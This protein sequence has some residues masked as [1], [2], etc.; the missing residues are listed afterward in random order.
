MSCW[1][2]DVS[3]QLEKGGDA[4]L[5]A[6]LRLRGWI[7]YLSAD[8]DGCFLVQN[9]LKA[10]PRRLQEEMAVELYGH[11][12]DAINSPHANFVIQVLVEI[13]PVPSTAFIAHELA[14]LATWVARHQYG[15]RILIRLLEHSTSQDS[16][17]A[18]VN[19]LLPHSQALMKHKF[20]HYVVRAVLEH[21]LTEQRRHVAAAM[22][23]HGCDWDEVL[24]NAT[25]RNAS[26]VFEAALAF[27]SRDD[28]QCFCECLLDR[29]ASVLELARSEFGCFVLKAL[30]GCSGCPD[31]HV[32]EAL[33][34]IQEA[35]TELQARKPGKMV[36]KHIQGAHAL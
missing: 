30:L 22:H 13:L 7:W 32:K 5:Q 16:T 1:C 26:T 6:I 14:G 34:T 18:L 27:C 17:I 15:C 3:K 23:G 8:E 28:Q 4:Q 20:G 19:E 36:L 35:K 33:K 21:G 2:C 29:P 10:A 11:V 31:K 9:A 24:K 12:R 25:N